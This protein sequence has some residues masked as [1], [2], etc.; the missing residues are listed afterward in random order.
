VALFQLQL[1]KDLREITVCALG[2]L[3]NESLSSLS[4]ARISFGNGLLFDSHFTGLDLLSVAEVVK[5]AEA[6]RRMDQKQFQILQLMA[7]ENCV[8]TIMDW[9]P[10]YVLATAQN[11]KLSTGSK[12]DKQFT[13]YDW[14]GTEQNPA[15]PPSHP[16]LNLRL[17]SCVQYQPLTEENLKIA[18]DRLVLHLRSTVC[19]WE[20]SWP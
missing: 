3:D 8:E 13:R 9:R 15:R 10:W 17:D 6:L 1:S 18:R 2:G 20:E 12:N 19:K 4:T 11:T 7:A 5:W 14:T 16:V